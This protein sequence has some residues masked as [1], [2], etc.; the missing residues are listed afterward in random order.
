MAET[1]NGKEVLARNKQCEWPIPQGSKCGNLAAGE[2]ESGLAYCEKHLWAV[3]RLR[4]WLWSAF[5]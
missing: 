2:T 5:Q 3:Q 1:V 4:W